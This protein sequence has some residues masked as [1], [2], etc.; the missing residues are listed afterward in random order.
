M[1]S[2]L[3]KASYL[4]QMAFKYGTATYWFSNLFWPKI[5]PKYI[6]EVKH[7]GTNNNKLVGEMT[8]EAV[9]V[10]Y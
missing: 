1:N 9:D 4:Y 5:A 10:K 2:I 7:K 6:P 3:L 8:S